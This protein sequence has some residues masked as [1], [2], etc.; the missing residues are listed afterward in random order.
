MIIFGHEEPQASHRHADV[1]A[2]PSE[3]VVIKA[4]PHTIYDPVLVIECKRIPAPSED[5]E[6]EYVTGTDP[7]KLSGGIQRFKLG[8][9]GGQMDMAAMVAYVQ[10]GIPHQWLQ[11]VNDWILELV[12]KPIGDGCPWSTDDIL[13]EMQEYTSN[14]VA[15]YHSVH[16]RSGTVTSSRIELHHLWIMMHT[17]QASR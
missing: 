2:L 15:S 17:S 8:Q 4:R 10:E 16:D 14:D 7:K 11:K 12:D 1:S 5:R 9:H 3:S 13:K 6:R